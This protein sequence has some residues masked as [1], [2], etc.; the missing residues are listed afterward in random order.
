MAAY[1]LVV[2]AS[3]RPSG[4][5]NTVANIVA[6]LTHVQMAAHVQGAC[7]SVR[8]NGRAQTVANTVAPLIHV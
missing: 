2:C 7:A 8:P 6:P 5:D 4:K 3:V 1:I